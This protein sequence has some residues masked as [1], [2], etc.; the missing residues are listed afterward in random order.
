MISWGTRY[1]SKGRETPEGASSLFVSSVPNRGGDTYY[2][3]KRRIEEHT[4]GTDE[5]AVE[6][7]ADDEITVSNTQPNPDLF[8]IW[9]L[10]AS[11]LSTVSAPAT[12]VV[13]SSVGPQFWET[14]FRSQMMRKVHNQRANLSMPNDKSATAE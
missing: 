2:S 11:A 5:Y 13:A 14:L 9:C 12:G 3:S 8:H 7:Q 4:F 6:L 1:V 10:S